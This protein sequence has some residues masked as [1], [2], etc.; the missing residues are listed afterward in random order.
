MSVVELFGVKVVWCKSWWS[1]SLLV[2]TGSGV[3]PSGPLVQK[4]FGV[5]VFW[6]QRFLLQ[7]GSNCLWCKKAPGVMASLSSGVKVL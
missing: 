5:R 1:K 4:L 2:E 3:K 7:F 6:C